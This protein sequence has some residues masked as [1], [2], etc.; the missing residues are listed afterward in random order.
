MQ[1]IAE[2]RTPEGFFD[3]DIDI[4]KEEWLA[5]VSDPEIKDNVYIDVLTKFLREP[6]HASTCKALGK[7]YDCSY[8]Y[9]NGAIMN[10]G[11]YVKK[12]LNRFYVEN[13]NGTESFWNIA[14]IG[15]H[16]KDGF[17]WRLRKEL[18]DALQEY[19]ISDLVS[20]YKKFVMS[21]AS[22]FSGERYKWELLTETKGLDAKGIL[23]AITK[24]GMNLVDMPRAGMAIKSLL[25]E[26]PE[27]I[28]AAFNELLNSERSFNENYSV[29]MGVIKPIA[30]T[31]FGFGFPDERTAAAFLTCARHDTY[32]F[33]MDKIYQ[34]YCHY[35]G[36]V[37]MPAG[38]KY[39]HYL[40][41][42]SRLAQM[43]NND[44]EL[45]YHLMEETKGLVWSDLLVGQDVLWEMQG[46]MIVKNSALGYIWTSF[47]EEFAD[48]LVPYAKKQ[49]EL[50]G[51]I[52][53][54]YAAIG[55]TMTKLSFDGEATA[56]DPFTVYGMFNKREGYDKRTELA[57]QLKVQFEMDSETPYRFDGIPVLNP[58]SA[59][60]YSFESEE[61]QH[62]INNLWAFFDAAIDYAGEISSK[63][64]DAFI[65]AYDIVRQQPRI[66]WNLTMGLFW[67]RPHSFISLDTNN[68]N[69]LLSGKV[70][71]E[72]AT[73]EIT[74]LL[75]KKGQIPTGEDYLRIC[76]IVREE[77]AAGKCPYPNFLEFS[78]VAWET[79]KETEEEVVDDE[80][81]N[82][83]DQMN[84]WFIVAS[85]SIWSASTMPVGAEEFYT[86][87]NENGNP[88]RI[89]KNFQAAAIGDPVLFY[90]A[91]PIMQAV[92]LGTIIS[93]DGQEL[94]FRKTANL[95]K[96]VDYAVLANTP[97]LAGMEFLSNKNGSLFRLTPEEYD[98]II[99]LSKVVDEESEFEPYTK[100]DFLADVFMDKSIYER[101]VS[102]LQIKKN[103]ILKGAP[104]VGKTYA[105]KRL[106][107]SIMGEK[108]TER[109]KFVQFHQS[110]SYEDFVMG[111]RPNDSGGF[112]LR[113]GVFYK[114]CKKAEMDPGH[115][116]YFIID[117][118]NRGNLSK[119]FGELFVLIEADKRG[120]EVQLAYR[121]ELFSVPKNLYI[122]GMLNT[123]DRSLA[124]IDYA[125]R[126]RFSFVE[127]EPA[128]EKLIKMHGVD[129]A[130]KLGKLLDE[131]KNLNEDIK[132]DPSLGSGFRIGHSYF[133][134]SEAV[135]DTN[136]PNIVEYEI[137]PMLEE[138]WFDNPIKATDWSE[139]LRSAIK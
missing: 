82:K 104:G 36:E 19:L 6:G 77:M 132:D 110:Y 31:K 137:V 133:C 8:G 107:Y 101:L 42:V 1:K 108:N 48:K 112:V 72:I 63:T 89:F 18:V 111:Y 117:E 87:Y 5:L 3:A 83:T 97:E 53:A 65:E 13:T 38:N 130:S 2:Y 128:I 47:Y 119:I 37:S 11:R 35:L 27:E 57:E 123:A 75:G 114:F 45:R 80:P 88:R 56:V 95:E 120:E 24:S 86:F 96:P 131:V 126:R 60:F 85:P 92:C 139:R 84:H 135:T 79:G 15:R 81:K 29:F 52:Q 71:S 129:P 105:A 14:M 90:E 20:R 121:D 4:T 67:M 17:E 99:E 122:I 78:R 115:D 116:Y 33:Y 12:K 98:K 43:A 64:R 49:E 138:Y 124:M 118:I 34:E 73:E 21:P 23:G 16:V 9:F 22:R 66:K 76:N 103:L 32:T 40:K 127:M 50:L 46:G 109:V 41:L 125:L 28:E 91:S 61:K 7:K 44:K 69:L 30:E 102:I 74:K 51:K 25:K 68:R 58:L 134:D 54:A 55:K 26:N 100:E 113:P 93:Q 62:H 39:V 59:A 136:L 70:L 106:A 10:F 94:H